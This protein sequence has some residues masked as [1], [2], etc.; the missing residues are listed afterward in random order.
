VQIPL[1]DSHCHLDDAAFAADRPAVLERAA[2]AGVRAVVLPAVSARYWP[3]LREVAAGCDGLY[4]AYGLHPMLLP[5]HLPE[6]LAELEQWLERERPVA[7]GECGL[8]FYVEDLDRQAQLEYF[9]A[10]LRLARDF[11]LPVILHA[12]RAVDEV[13]KYIRR[14]PGLRGVVHSFSGS[15]QQAQR[16]FQLGFRVG[17]GGPL[18]YPRAQRLRSVA[19]QLPIEAIVLETDAPDQPGLAQ[20]GRR[21][22]PA[23]IVEVLETLADLRGEMPEAVGRA[24]T[25][26]ARALFG[27][28]PV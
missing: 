24:T 8:D 12:R 15:L 26:N 11:D 10:Q 19:A 25:Q 5:E 27:L 28:P 6:H 7:V 23:F 3:R 13:L 22:E 17:L 9:V 14:Y 1:I 2:G 21:N 4:A 20:R 18:T 16:L